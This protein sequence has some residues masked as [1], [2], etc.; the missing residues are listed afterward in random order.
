M[1]TYRHIWCSTESPT[2]SEPK[3][4][5]ELQA[6]LDRGLSAGTGVGASAAVILP[7]GKIW[8]G[9]SGISHAGAPVATDMLFDMGSAGKNLFG[10]LPY[11]CDITVQQ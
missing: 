4:A 7:D 5:Q 11:I 6:A 9:A 2:A 10:T 1:E 3:L 8:T